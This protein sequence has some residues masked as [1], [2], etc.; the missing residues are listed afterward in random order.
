VNISKNELFVDKFGKILSDDKLK[1]IEKLRKFLIE[2]EEILRPTE[3]ES[4]YHTV[5][6]RDSYF[7]KNVIYSLVSSKQTIIKA[8]TDTD[9][10]SFCYYIFGHYDETMLDHIWWTQKPGINIK[11]GDIVKI[12]LELMEKELLP[13]K[14][15]IVQMYYTI[16]GKYLS[17]NNYDSA[18]LSSVFKHLSS[19]KQDTILPKFFAVAKDITEQDV[20]NCEKV[21][22]FMNE[23]PET[24]HDFYLPVEKMLLFL[25]DLRNLDFDVIVETPDQFVDEGTRYLKEKIGSMPLSEFA[26]EHIYCY[27]LTDSMMYD[28]N[29][30]KVS[31]PP[32]E[33]VKKKA[34]EVF[35]CELIEKDKTPC[36]QVPSGSNNFYIVVDQHMAVHLSIVDEYNI[37][38][39]KCAVLL[40]RGYYGVESPFDPSK[41]K[42][43]VDAEAAKAKYDKYMNVETDFVTQYNQLIVELHKENKALIR[44]CGK[45]RIKE[46]V[47]NERM[48]C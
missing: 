35:E 6:L 36:F 31:N 45:L 33:E 39:Q 21:L 2:D 37:A 11:K 46:C 16:F 44:H 40:S 30:V 47:D 12:D 32:Y 41:W 25:R 14:A 20:L 3:S 23:V 43:D 19:I 42:D 48:N 13:T 10:E 29:L 27:L 15:Y 5:G 17:L 34:G 18:Q 9:V 24:I 22:D 28:E 7:I 8:F 4:E 38:V 1:K 26:G